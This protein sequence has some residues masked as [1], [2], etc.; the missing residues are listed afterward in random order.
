MT[1]LRFAWAN[2]RASP[3]ASLVNV[4][5]MTLGTASIVL[6]LLAGERLAD[7]LSRDARGI[8]LVLGAKGSPT[9]LILAAVY[10]AD[11]PPGNISLQEAQTWAAD[12][13]IEL[14]VPLSLGDSFRGFRIVGTDHAFFDLFPNELQSGEH[15]TTSMEAV[16]GA[17]VAT[18]AGLT[19][20]DHFTGAHGF[21]DGGHEHESRAY[22]V[23]G[24]LEPSATAADRL[25]LTSL[26][27][28]WELH[29]A[30]EHAD[31]HDDHH[32]DSG[33]QNTDTQDIDE[34]EI[35]AMLLRYRT[36]LAALALP[37]EINAR[38]N[39]QAASPALEVA[40][41]LNLVGFGLD[42]LRVF[43]WVLIATASLSVFAALY[44]SLRHRR[45]DLAML[46]CLGATRLELFVTTLSEGMVL[47]IG[48]IVF[49]YALGHGVMLFVE[50]WLISSKGVALAELTWAPGETDLLFLM[51]VVS[52]V[53]AALPAA[54]AYR[55]DVARTLAEA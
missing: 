7:T 37:R 27:S 14:A 51:L 18:E 34:A 13:R 42:G 25:I 54:E 32:H 16:L 11:I 41:L 20:G 9:Q 22:H 15:W 30:V 50:R 43:A 19:L 31:E 55:T 4:L 47:S 45:R 44:G 33:D 48:G 2:L 6:L 3:I 36:P 35:T 21:S 24:I 46:R 52:V 29:E 40:R 23:V 28:V 17:T 53:S 12:G 39:L 38:G 10:H 26:D 49:G 5:L 8:D 1:W